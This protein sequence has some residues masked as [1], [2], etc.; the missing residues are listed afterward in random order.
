VGSRARTSFQV[1]SLASA[2]FCSPIGDNEPQHAFLGEPTTS[3]V[4]LDG[5]LLP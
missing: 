5:I 3:L 2:L 4:Y 1:V